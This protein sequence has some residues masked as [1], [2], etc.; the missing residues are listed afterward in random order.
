[1]TQPLILS[2]QP[3]DLYAE[4]TFARFGQFKIAAEPTLEG[5]MR[6]IAPA[7]ALVVRGQVQITAALMDA[8]PNLKV[9]GR[10]GVGY[11]TVDID[12]ATARGIAVVYTPGAGARAVAEA[13]FAFMLALCK[14]IAHW[15]HETKKGNWQARIASQGTDLDQKTLGIIGLGRIGQIVAKMA[16]PFEMNVVAYDPYLDPAVARAL[17]VKLIDL[18]TLMAQADFVTLHCPQNDETMGLINRARLKQM[19]PGAFLIN[20]ARGGVIE[21][22]DPIYEMLVSGHLRGAALDVFLVEPPDHTHPIFGLQNCLVSPHAMATSEGAMR[23][24]YESM[25][26]DMTAILA[27][28]NPHYVVNPEVLRRS[29]T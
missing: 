22:L 27:G 9:I 23:R 19:K 26:N 21:S 7:I 20:L 24:I 3:L 18:D 25:A 11:D 2:T 29:T 8:A 6:E 14:M 1:M 5:L 4:Q 13:A 28:N 16:K 15:D 17:E 12:A 10:T